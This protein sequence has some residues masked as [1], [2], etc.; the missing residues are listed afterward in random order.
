MENFIYV[1]DYTLWKSVT[2]GLYSPYIVT[3]ESGTSIPKD[4]SKYTDKELKWKEIDMKA[5]SLLTIA[6]PSEIYQNYNTYKSA[7]TLWDD[8][9]MYTIPIRIS[10]NLNTYTLDE[11]YGALQSYEFEEAQLHET[12]I[13]STLVNLDQ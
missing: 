5:L 12:T 1:T 11:L 3:A 9:S 13:K 4:I 10:E 7:K 2:D 8:L 6:L